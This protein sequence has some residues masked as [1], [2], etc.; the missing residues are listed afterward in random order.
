MKD[1]RLNYRIKKK[2][3]VTK[4]LSFLSHRW[5]ERLQHPPG[6]GVPR[7]GPLPQP[8]AGG[9]EQSRSLVLTGERPPP[10]LRLLHVSVPQPGAQPVQV[11]WTQHTHRSEASSRKHGRR[12][13]K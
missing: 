12:V 11:T 2:K 7:G 5:R 4:V 6:E 9:A 1:P 13:F 3:Q 10:A 8:V